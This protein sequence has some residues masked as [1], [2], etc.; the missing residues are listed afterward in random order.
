MKQITAT[1]AGIISNVLVKQTDVVEVGQE[2]IV[3]ESMKMQIPI[4]SEIEGT[5]KEVKVKPGDF[6]NDGDIMLVLE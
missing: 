2:V 5:V 6:I 3:I 4:E 1:I